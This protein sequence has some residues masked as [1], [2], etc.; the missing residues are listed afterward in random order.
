MSFD[1]CPSRFDLSHLTWYNLIPSKIAQRW[2][3][4]F[5]NCWV[6]V[7]CVYI[8]QFSYPSIRCRTSGLPPGSDYYKKCIS[9]HK[10]TQISCDKF[11]SFLWVYPLGEKLTDHRVGLFLAFWEVSILF[12]TGVRPM[13]NP[14]PVQ[15]CPLLPISSPIFIIVLSDSH[16]C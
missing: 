4:Y 5:F 8:P 12:S 3:P 1:I 7:H 9:E 14:T 15:N 11:F 6:K 10:Y 13:H 2:W 16:S